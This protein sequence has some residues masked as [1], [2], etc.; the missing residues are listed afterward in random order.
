MATT[1]E[2]AAIEKE[3]REQIQAERRAVKKE[4]RRT[5]KESVRRSNQKYRAKLKAEK[6]RAGNE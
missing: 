2:R 6:E 5:H 4:W 1:E 3:I